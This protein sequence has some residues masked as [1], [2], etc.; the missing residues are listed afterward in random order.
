MKES[1][2][3][4]LA[5]E[6][7]QALQV[8]NL[9]ARTING[10]RFLLEK[11]FLFLAER[12]VTHTDGITK[13]VIA[14]YQTELYH[15]VNHRGRPNCVGY[16]N[17]R[18]AAVKGFTRF[19]KERDYL[20]ADPAQGIPYAKRPQ[21]LPRGILT[22]AEARKVINAP[23][24][25]CAVGYRDHT[26]L[27]VLYTTGIRKEELNQLTLADVDY[28]DGFLRINGGKGNKDRVVPLGRIACRYLENYIKSVRPEFIKDPYNHHLFLSTRGNRLSKNVVWKLVKKYAKQAKIKKTISPHTFRHSCATAMLRNKAD[29]RAVQELLGHES[30][31][32]TQIYT[33]ISIND[34]KETHKRCHPREQEKE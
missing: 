13:G 32:S 15:A 21:R 18:M 16:Q 34:L 4:P 26:I 20:V 2:L 9:S 30:L 10:R 11:F 25:K 19:L 22:P 31:E 8:R 12:G 27:E 5:A 7:L 23:D 24:T 3:S 6:Y 29:I 33:H 17:G 14:D 1:N 28:D